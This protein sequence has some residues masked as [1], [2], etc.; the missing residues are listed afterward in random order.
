VQAGGTSSSYSFVIPLNDCGTV[1]SGGFGRTVDNII[2]I[3]TDDTV[4]V[5][6]LEKSTAGQVNKK[7]PAFMNLNVHSVFTRARHRWLS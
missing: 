2:V 4:Q 5:S 3:Q 6:L 1:P 7:F